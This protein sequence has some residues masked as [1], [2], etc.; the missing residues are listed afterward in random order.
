MNAA[1]ITETRQFNPQIIRDHLSMLPS[2][3]ELIVFCA[4]RNLRLFNEFDCIKYKVVV[5]NLHDYNRLLTSVWFWEKLIDYDRVLI[6][7]TDSKILRKG[8]EEYYYYDYL[9]A[10][11][12]F[13]DKCGN[14]GLS[15]R[16]PKVM[17]EMVSTLNYTGNPYED[18][19]FSNNIEKF[20]NLA[21]REVCKKFSCETIFEL[22][23]W[24]YHAIESYMTKDQ[25]E[26]IEN[27]YNGKEIKENYGI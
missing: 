8:I 27:Q 17:Y 3:F 25:I 19:W 1:V 16:N 4:D 22:G 21:P 2:D 23:T 26:K 10:P 12:K 7:Q 6:F 14:G 11:W 5:N 13:Q 9:G 18:V 15:L 20:G 24:G